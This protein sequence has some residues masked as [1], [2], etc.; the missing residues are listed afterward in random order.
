MRPPEIDPQ[1][2]LEKKIQWRY[3]KGL[4]E[5]VDSTVFSAMTVI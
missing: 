1:T 5:T 3:A 4:P 2:F